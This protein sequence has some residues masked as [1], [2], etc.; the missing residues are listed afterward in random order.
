VPA[1]PLS[2][3]GGIWSFWNIKKGATSRTIKEQL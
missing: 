3:D 1:E 2:L